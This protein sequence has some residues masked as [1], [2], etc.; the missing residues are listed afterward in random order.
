MKK[1]L[2]SMIVLSI[3]LATVAGSYFYSK[4]DIVALA[5]NQPEKFTIEDG[6]ESVKKI[7][8]NDKT[9]KYKETKSLDN[10]EYFVYEDDSFEFDLTSNSGNISRVSNKKVTPTRNYNLDSEN[11]KVK[12]L[13]NIQ[14]FMPN[15]NIENMKLVKN[16]KF[17]GGSFIEQQ[18]EWKE[19]NTDGIFTGTSIFV[20][21]NGDGELQS[22]SCHESSINAKELLNAPEKINK[23]EAIDKAFSKVQNYLKEIGHENVLKTKDDYS[24]LNEKMVYK[25]NVVWKV[26]INGIQDFVC[27][28]AKIDFVIYINCSTGEIVDFSRTL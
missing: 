1:R 9:L 8:A 25:E 18:L 11:A 17:D 24:I 2:I 21:L 12:G 28:D 26:Q 27:P 4:N 13:N 14:K 3:C 5:K 7:N 22:L 16:K 6:I 10:K 20:I 15:A 19:Y 23:T